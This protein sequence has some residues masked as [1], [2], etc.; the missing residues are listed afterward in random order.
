MRRWGADNEERAA[1]TQKAQDAYA[2]AR[3][4]MERINGVEAIASDLRDELAEAHAESA[5]L[6]HR[7]AVLERQFMAATEPD[8]KPR[9]VKKAE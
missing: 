8:P 2:L 5:A 4:A 7:I 3:Q 9:A 1:C 6:K